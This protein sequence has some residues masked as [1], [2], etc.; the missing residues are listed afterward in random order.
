M[1]CF[2]R[3]TTR[4]ARASARP[5]AIA[6][7]LLG[8][9]FLAPA[10]RGQRGAENTSQLDREVWSVLAK[11]SDSEMRQ[12]GQARQL[13]LL[14][15]RAIPVLFDAWRGRG[16]PAQLDEAPLTLAAHRAQRE[17]IAAVAEAALGL[18]QSNGL[19]PY[20]QRF[21]T[22]TEEP[23]ER[24][25]VLQLLGRI[26]RREAVALVV[27]IVKSM[28]A[29]L[30]RSPIEQGTVRRCVAGILRRDPR[31]FLALRSRWASLPADRVLY[32]AQAVAD[33]GDT[34]AS[35]FLLSRV[36]KTGALDPDLLTLVTERLDWVL[37]EDEPRLSETL[38][39]GLWSPD[40]RMQRAAA[41]AV[42]KAQDLTLFEDTVRLLSADEPDVRRVA[43]N[44]LRTLSGQNLAEDPEAWISWYADALGWWESEGEGLLEDCESSD[45]SV[46]LAAMRALSQHP[47]HRDAA[48]RTLARVSQGGDPVL[49]RAACST[50]AT[51]RS[52]LAIEPL[53]F[54]LDDEDER[55]RSAAWQSLRQLT[56]RDLPLDSSAWSRA[57]VSLKTGRS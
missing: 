4:A 55:V 43:R 53:R 5:A 54:A 47:L 37:E 17:R 20:L 8:V 7:A 49:R 32:F 24:L 26:G 29:E 25:V 10:A 18:L 34:R 38:R 36:G 30:T 46:A 16:I 3:P 35:R 44:A 12:R 45:R 22:G 31:A 13:A 2:L 50:L 21:A 42:A 27:T 48:S 51:L 19:H 1:P 57:T 56:G 14:G 15:E 33:V 52:R 23:R 41:H 28:D 39:A 6:C 40:V 9:L 11:A